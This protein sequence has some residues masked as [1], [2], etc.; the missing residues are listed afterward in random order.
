MSKEKVAYVAPDTG[1]TLTTRPKKRWVAVI[2]GLVATLATA[3]WEA[4]P[5]PQMLGE[6]V[7]A[8]L[9]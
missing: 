1:E 2:A 3:L 4:V 5:V 7:A 9:G 6:L 8:A